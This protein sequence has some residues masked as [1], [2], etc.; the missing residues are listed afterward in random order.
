MF[1]M[2]KDLTYR[3]PVHFG[4]HNF[5][6]ETKLT[7]KAISL[8]F[9][10][11]TDKDLLENYVPEEFELL[12]SE[13]QVVFSKFTEINW[14]L[15]GTYN[16]VDV[17]LPVRFEGEENQLDGKY[18][19]VVWEN[20]TV[21]I[22]GGREETGIPK[23]FADIEDLQIIKPYYAT[24]ASLNGNTFLNL[25]FEVSDEVVG[26]ELDGLKSLSS[27]VN[28]IG[29]RYI[30]K[31]GSPGTELSQFVLYPQ[32]INV[33]TAHLGKGNIKWN[34]VTPMQNPS[35]HSIINSLANLPIKKMNDA[36]LIEGI[37]ILRAFGASVLK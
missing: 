4:G 5:D 13:L 17:S 7:Q 3:M 15:G 18:P 32:G 30:P 31:V 25:N 1:K 10:Y 34:E 35:Q 33:E 37:A 14:M 2:E 23:I 26:Q 9:S 19:L 6:P 12:S 22:L 27:S 36:L 24:S 28:T 11:E 21:P 20:N 8:M 16:L 29:W